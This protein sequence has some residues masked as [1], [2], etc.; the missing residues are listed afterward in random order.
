M[1]IIEII[2][3]LS[4][5]IAFSVI[6]GFIDN[7]WERNTLRGTVFQGILFGSVAVF[8]ILNPFVLSEG[9]IFD[10]RSVVISIC[11]LFFG[12]YAG[13]IT[14]LMALIAR[15]YIGGS[16][17]IMGSSVILASFI[18][19]YLFH[20][21]KKTDNL[22]VLLLYVMGVAVHV[23]MLSLMLFLPSGMRFATFQTIAITI[24]IFYPIGT[25]LIGKILSDQFLSK[26]LIIDLAES[27][28]NLSIT[29]NSIGDGV[30]ATNSNGLITKMNPVAEKFTGWKLNDAINL[31]FS[32]VFKIITA[33]TRELIESPIQ[34]VLKSGE[35]AELSNHTILISKNGT[36]LSISD[37]AAPIRD[38]EGNIC[39]AVVV[40]SD[41]T[42][43]YESR[44]KLKESEQMYRLLVENLSEGIWQ[45]NKYG[46][47]VFVNKAMAEMLN[48]TPAEMEGKHL[49]DFM[50]ETNIQIAKDNIKRREQGISEQHD[51]EF[52]KKDGGRVQVLI[53]TVP[54]QNDN[55][56]YIGA[57][58]GVLDVTQK[59][60]AQRELL[61]KEKAIESALN[62][63]ALADLSGNLTYVNHSFLKLWGFQNTEQALGKAVTDFWQ[64]P[65]TAMN[66]VQELYKFGKWTGELIGEKADKSLF[67]ANVSANFVEDENNQPI[68][69]LASFED[70]TQEKLTKIELITAKEKAEE[71]D[72]LK[73]AFLQNMSHEIRTPMNGIIGFT[74]LLK[75][76]DINPTDFSEYLSIIQNSGN[77]LLDLVNNILDISKIETGQMKVNQ[78]SFNLNQLIMDLYS[79]FQPL[80]HNK[81]NELRYKIDFVGNDTA[82]VSDFSKLNQVLSNL[83]NNAIKFTENGMISFG[84]TMKIDEIEF[85]VEDIGSG[86]PEEH[87]ERIFDRFY[88]A[89]IAMNRN[90]E[91]AGLG[92]AICKGLVTL[93]GGKIGV[94]SE[95]GKG[96]KFIF[97]IP[98]L[99]G[100][101][102]IMDN[103]IE[104]TKRAKLSKRFK[105][106]VAEDDFTNYKLIERLF[107]KESNAEILH[108]TNGLDAVEIYKSMPDIPIV[109]MD[110][111]MPIMDGLTATTLIKQINENVKIIAVTAYAFETD[112]D[113]ALAGACDDYISKPYNLNDLLNKVEQYL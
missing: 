3:N 96:T 108:A 64:N 102:T 87:L 5:L 43:V 51:F 72:N 11:T 80:A 9:L 46:Y 38:F 78:S 41:N 82:I 89:D 19:G 91:G 34:K 88:Q 26:K 48:L 70:I 25:V 35:T 104:S 36:E 47:T 68:C 49:F 97:N 42:A 74:E 15:A 31:P 56:E 77:R 107:R 39:G 7:R 54:L 90:Y 6:S 106:L 24:I 57:L 44:K 50:D 37:S 83:L 111:K 76:T 105:L 8:G 40:F 65:D 71:S 13:G 30:I 75:H 109:L 112:R 62:A 84:Y 22:S 101:S 18:I 61:I 93:L 27:E 52:L 95:I 17:L 53:E 113:R 2:Y 60:F 99:E 69:L 32:N 12:P 110:L 63:I 10:G 28:E 100:N 23:V 86:I 67:Y 73:T 21:F 14:A 33:D 98:L 29:L 16:G 92:L 58:A 85:F 4:L 55:G 20:H 94:E 103:Q 59:K 79:F 66:V 81:N 1:L 45:I